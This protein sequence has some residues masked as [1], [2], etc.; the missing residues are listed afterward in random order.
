MFV[1]RFYKLICNLFEL[2][3]IQEQ[4]LTETFACLIVKEKKK[5][6]QF[7]MLTFF[8]K[9]YFSYKYL[10]RLAYFAQEYHK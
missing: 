6:L 3:D 5:K 4:V 2:I 8:E 7:T 10:N 1:I 9:K